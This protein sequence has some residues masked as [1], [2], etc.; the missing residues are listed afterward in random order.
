MDPIDLGP[1]ENKLNLSDSDITTNHLKEIN[2]LKSER[3]DLRDQL[4]SIKNKV[5]EYYLHVL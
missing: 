4:N 2:R 5:N 3:D 1:D